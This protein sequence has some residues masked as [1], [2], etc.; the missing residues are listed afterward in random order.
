MANT[1]IKGIIEAGRWTGIPKFLK[2][3]CFFND[4][5]LI[6]DID[7]GWLT[8]TV[9]YQISGD[10]K[11]VNSVRDDIREALEFYETGGKKQK[12]A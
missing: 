6:M 10:S 7:K 3:V 9:R 4:V 1:T 8:E 5:K 12:V 2:D 11:A